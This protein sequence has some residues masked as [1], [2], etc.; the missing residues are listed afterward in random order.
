MSI[1]SNLT[2]ISSIGQYGMRELLFL[3]MN[4][5]QCIC[6]LSI[7]C[8]N[9]N[10]GLLCKEEALIVHQIA[11]FVLDLNYNLPTATT[12]TCSAKTSSK[13]LS[14]LKTS[15]W[16][17]KR[18]RLREDYDP[19]F[20]CWGKQLRSCRINIVT[21]AIARGRILTEVLEIGR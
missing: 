8:L 9:L 5:H 6:K 10:C 20:R 16:R 7:I 2:S 12:A 17:R 15:L 13:S 18:R 3:Y 4:A 19:G 11:L 21:L 1:L 14:C